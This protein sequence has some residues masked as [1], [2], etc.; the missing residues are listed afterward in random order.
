M[1]YVNTHVSYSAKAGLYILLVGWKNSVYTFDLVLFFALQSVNIVKYT[2]ESLHEYQSRLPMPGM[3]PWL[4]MMY[5]C[6]ACIHI[7][8]G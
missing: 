5:S 1:R 8:F 6:V 3:A 2:S 4:V 7:L